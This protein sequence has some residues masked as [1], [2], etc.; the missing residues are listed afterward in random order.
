M[1][2]PFP[3]AQCLAVGATLFLGMK[4]NVSFLDVLSCVIHSGLSALSTS[5]VLRS[6]IR[7]DHQRS[8]LD[9]AP[10]L[11]K[12]TGRMVMSHVYPPTA[13]DVSM[14]PFIPLR[15]LSSLRWSHTL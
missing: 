11:N 2:I 7:C 10:E 3:S 14:P 15:L 6:R 5:M 4:V 8:R 9:R 12:H 1:L 13:L